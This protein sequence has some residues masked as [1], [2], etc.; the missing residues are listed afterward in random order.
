M[1]LSVS[2]KLTLFL[3]VIWV[4]VIVLDSRTAYLAPAAM[5]SRELKNVRRRAVSL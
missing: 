4:N 3:Q 5:Q 1:A 2:R